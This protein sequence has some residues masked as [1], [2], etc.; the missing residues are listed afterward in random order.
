MK[1]PTI[2]GIFISISRENSLLS[3][4]EHEKSFITLGPGDLSKHGCLNDKQEDEQFDS[5]PA[6]FATCIL[7]YYLQ[8]SKCPKISNKKYLTKWHM[9]TVQTQIRLLLKDQSDQDQY[10]LPFH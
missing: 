9:Q 7:S 4:V 3:L 1:M 5:G 2:V 8:Y 10:C 6:L